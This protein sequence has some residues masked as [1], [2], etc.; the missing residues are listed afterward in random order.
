VQLPKMH[1]AM[2]ALK[3]IKFNLN[4]F[5]NKILLFILT[6]PFYCLFAVWIRMAGYKN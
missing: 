3:T 1:N 2:N 4:A 6:T 5:P